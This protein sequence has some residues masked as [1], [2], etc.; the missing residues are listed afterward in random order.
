MKITFEIILS[1]W[2]YRFWTISNLD[3]SLIMK[4][5]RLIF[6]QL[7]YKIRSAKIEHRLKWPTSYLILNKIIWHNTGLLSDQE[8]WHMCSRWAIGIPKQR[9]WCRSDVVLVF[10]LTISSDGTTVDFEQVNAN[11]VSFLSSTL[12][13]II[14]GVNKMYVICIFYII[15]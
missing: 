7:I 12:T 14:P 3:N 10:A 15:L 13:A 11:L 2:N 4:W 1:K 6:F 5:R 8:L 9:W